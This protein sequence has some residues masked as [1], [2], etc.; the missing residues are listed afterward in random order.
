MA[1]QEAGFPAA[2]RDFLRS[3]RRL[4]ESQGG[5]FKVPTFC[6]KELDLYRVYREVQSRGG[7]S[8]VC[9]NKRWREVCRALG[10]DLEGQTSASNIM[11]R[12]YE[13][14]LLD[15]ELQETGEVL[16]EDFEPTRSGKK[17][18]PGLA[19]GVGVGRFVFLCL[20]AGKLTASLA[21]QLTSRQVR[22]R[23]SGGGGRAEE[24]PQ[25]RRGRWGF[26]GL[27]GGPLRP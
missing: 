20:Q 19:H 13:K 7:Y 22:Q 25:G 17:C 26:R 3:L 2:K 27:G 24:R 6:G 9:E 18:A 8:A 21:L 12:N 4:I 1:A 16:P 15:Y 11:K 10:V 5:R 14:I 23:R